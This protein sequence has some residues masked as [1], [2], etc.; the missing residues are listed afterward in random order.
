MSGWTRP[1]AYTVRFTCSIESRYCHGRGAIAHKT[2][3]TTVDVLQWAMS[4]EE[5]IE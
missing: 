5:E 2:N 4:T 1:H 3:I